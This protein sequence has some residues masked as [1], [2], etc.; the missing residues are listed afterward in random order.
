MTTDPS[1]AIGTALSIVDD[2]WSE[3][4][5]GSGWGAPPL[6]ERASLPDLSLEETERRAAVGVALAARI[7]ALDLASLPHELALTVRFAGTY[8]GRW[9]NEGKWYWTA[10]DSLG[11]GFFGLFGP[12]PYAGGHL[13]GNLLAAFGTMKLREEG[14]FDRYLGFVSDFARVLRQMLER[15]QGQA[16]RGI[17]MPQAQLAQAVSL[18]QAL[19]TRARDDLAIGAAR[20][21]VDVPSG[22][23]SELQRRVDRVGQA[24]DAF[25]AFLGP[26]YARRA[27]ETVGMAQYKDG[28]EIYAALVREHTTLDLTPAEVHRIG[29]E[30]MAQIRADMDSVRGEAKFD[31]DDHAYRAMLDVIPAWRADTPDAVTALFRVYIERIKP[32]LSAYFSFLPEAAHDAAPLPDSLAGAM[33]FGFYDPPAV[34]RTIGRYLYNA[35]NLTQR[36]LFNVGALNYHELMPGHHLHF[37]SQQ[38][39]EALHPLRRNGFIN[40]FNEGWAE[41]AATL[42]GEMGMYEQPAERFGRLVMDAF[43]TS[44]LVVDT[45][46]NALGWSLERARDYMRENAFLSE[47]EIRTETV[48]YS[49]DIPGQ[50]LAYKLGDVALMR[51]RTKMRDALGARFDIKRFHDA[52]LRPGALPLSLVEGEVDR[53][54]AQTA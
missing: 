44:R 8:A 53:A 19:Q 43:L 6:N 28:P 14:D 23:V 30:R 33:S 4:R 10:Q 12:T 7:D 21:P 36:G 26:D 2:A 5:R 29:L 54:I 46:M 16:S 40:A 3:L 48:R 51:L 49:C 45:G 24:F 32:K 52:V 38:E 42:A 17:Y 35:R 34:P 37:A 22:F 11:V 41:Y 31:G 9:R 18:L 1:F 27:P 25:V 39:N 13:L 20:L 47:A 15:T 50:S